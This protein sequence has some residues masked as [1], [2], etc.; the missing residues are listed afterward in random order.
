MKRISALLVA[1]LA[2][3]VPMAAHAQSY[4]ERSIRLIVPF[5]AGGTVDTLARRTAQ[6]MEAGL[7]QPVVIDN[8]PGANG[9]IGVEAVIKAAPDGYT[10]LFNSAS[11]LINQVI[12]PGIR[13]DILRDLVPVS[14]AMGL[15]SY[16]LLVNAQSPYQNLGALLAQARKQPGAMNYASPG[17][18]NGQHLLMETLNYKA[19]VRMTHIP[20]KGIPDMA[21]ALMRNE[22]DSMVLNPLL[23]EPHLKSGKFRAIAQVSGTTARLPSLPDLPAFSETLPGFTWTA[24]RFGFFFPVQTPRAI[25]VRMQGE[26]AKA[27]QTPELKDYLKTGGFVAV[28]GTPQEFTEAIASDLQRFSEIARIA[29]IKA[30]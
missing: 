22:V 13:Y 10:M 29:N 23:A 8:R 17:V 27:L 1:L 24:G 7:K 2:A 30:N 28:G 11:M 4:P 20:Y 18:G 15:D 6:A 25:V 19:G 26:I 14:E 16:L 5:P 12:N 9:V 3:M 21:T